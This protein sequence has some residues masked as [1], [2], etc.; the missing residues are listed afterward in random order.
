[1]G[2]P[3]K[4]DFVIPH[5]SELS[6]ISGP[7]EVV[8]EDYGKMMLAFTSVVFEGTEVDGHL[9]HLDTLD[10]FCFENLSFRYYTECFQVFVEFLQ[11]AL[12]DTGGSLGVLSHPGLLQKGGS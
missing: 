10:R 6:V 8:L 7:L 9:Y 12:C 3:N 5:D 2:H 1:M 11:M 4:A